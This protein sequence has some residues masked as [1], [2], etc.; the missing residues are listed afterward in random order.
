VRS[1]R[2]Q[3]RGA[4]VTEPAALRRS[5]LEETEVL[6]VPRCEVEVR[7]APRDAQR[8]AAVTAEDVADGT[9]RARL[10]D[11]LQRAGGLLA[12]NTRAKTR[13]VGLLTLQPRAV[14]PKLAAR[15]RADDGIPEEP[16]MVLEEPHHVSAL[17]EGARVPLQRL[18]GRLRLGGGGDE[19]DDQGADTQ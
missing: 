1:L 13:N 2:L 19:N 9:A 10:A 6:A 14:D 4:T 17:L 3:E 16:P 11:R 8:L 12:A 15:F 18:G 7:L 5:H